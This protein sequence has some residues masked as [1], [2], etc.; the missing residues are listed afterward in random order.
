MTP[1]RLSDYL[2][3]QN[4]KFYG[5]KM[6]NLRK[7]LSKSNLPAIYNILMA[8]SGFSLYLRTLWSCPIELVLCSLNKFKGFL[9]DN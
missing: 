8:L 6:S 9:W 1:D 5:C 4:P 2:V 3:Y 7:F